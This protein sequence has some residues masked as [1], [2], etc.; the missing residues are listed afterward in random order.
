[1]TAEE[2]CAEIATSVVTDPLD[3]RNEW[4]PGVEPDLSAITRRFSAGMR[5]AQG[6]FEAGVFDR[7]APRRPHRM[8]LSVSERGVMIDT[9]D[10]DA[11]RDASYWRGYLQ[12]LQLFAEAKGYASIDDLVRAGAREGALR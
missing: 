5:R 10:Q 9:D 2:A 8:Y 6:D 3:L 11:K 1:M 7:L 4:R 12:A